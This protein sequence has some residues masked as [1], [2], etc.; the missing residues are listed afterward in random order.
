[1][2]CQQ[3]QAS[4][5]RHSNHKEKQRN[6]TEGEHLSSLVW[7]SNTHGK[8]TETVRAQSDRLLTA[9]QKLTSA[10]EEVDMGNFCI[11]FGENVKELKESLW[12]NWK[13]L[14]KP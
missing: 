5:K 4:G 3:Q 14:R 8:S 9:G 13:F 10:G 1:M 12:T 7:P 6:S 11:T 2:G